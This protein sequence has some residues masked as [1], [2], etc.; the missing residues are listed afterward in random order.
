[1]TR[2]R[3]PIPRSRMALRSKEKDVVILWESK[4]KD[5]ADLDR[6]VKEFQD[7]LEKKRKG[8]LPMYEKVGNP[9]QGSGTASRSGVLR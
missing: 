9:S 6:R 3:R 5:P 4:D 7:H 8:L 2:R 1:M